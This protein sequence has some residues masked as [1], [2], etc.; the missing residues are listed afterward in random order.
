MLLQ[1]WYIFFKRFFLLSI[2]NN[3]KIPLFELGCLCVPVYFGCFLA[4]H[5]SMVKRGVFGT[6][7][8]ASIVISC[9]ISTANEQNCNQTA[10]ECHSHFRITCVETKSSDNMMSDECEARL[11]KLHSLRNIFTFFYKYIF[12]N[13]H[14]NIYVSKILEHIF[15]IISCSRTGEKKTISSLS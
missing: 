11:L 1:R 12:R 3:R 15:P 13:C 2:D 6:S 9:C 7:K 4:L 5:M 8:V 14:E 10:N